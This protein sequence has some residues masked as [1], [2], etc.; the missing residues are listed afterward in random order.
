MHSG[1]FP[2][3]TDPSYFDPCLDA[4]HPTDTAEVPESALGFKR[5]RKKGLDVPNKRL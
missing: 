4:Y 5:A 1:V 3:E 2:R